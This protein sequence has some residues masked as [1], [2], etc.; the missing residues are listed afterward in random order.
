MLIGRSVRRATRPLA[1]ATERLPIDAAFQRTVGRAAV[2]FICALPVLVVVGI[3]LT[4]ADAVFAFQFERLG[5]WFGGLEFGSVVWHAIVMAAVAWVTL[6]LMWVVRMAAPREPVEGSPP[7]RTIDPVSA[8]SFL[9]ALE[10]LYA[11]FVLV[12]F[13][14]LF[15]A[16]GGT[17]P[18]GYTYA[19]YARRGFFEL[20]VVTAIN[21]A[22]GSVMAFFVRRESERVDRA[23][24]LAL[25]GLMLLGG[26]ILASAWLR[27]SLYE[28]SYGYTYLRV[29]A[30]TM[31]VLMGGTLALLGWK[32]WHEEYKFERA[33][34]VLALA[35]YIGLNFFAPD[36]FIASAN[37]D[38]YFASGRIDTEYLAGLAWEATPQLSRLAEAPDGTVKEWAAAELAARKAQLDQPMSWT[39]WNLA[40]WNA[41]RTLRD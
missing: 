7:A 19:E 36:R 8:I 39:G 13:R 1:R 24:G 40:R 29:F 10:A 28:E 18:P 35:L 17:L 20:C 2:G 38:R 5:R 37:I 31:I 11:V 16:G 34:V 27:L 6:G 33:V 12:Q 25:A 32:A 15:A 23:V 22:L 21:I 41:H 26:A 30:R 9:I 4:S 3:L 14:Y